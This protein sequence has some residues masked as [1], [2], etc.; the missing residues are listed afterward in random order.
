MTDN[1]PG[2]VDASDRRALL[3]L[4]QAV[5]EQ[6]STGLLVFDPGLRYLL[7]NQQMAAM[8]NTPAEALLGRTV[9]EAFPEYAGL[10]A[11]IEQVLATGEPMEAFD[12]SGQT[13]GW[14][15]T[16]ERGPCR[17]TG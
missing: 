14:W 4:L 15:A 6:S 16:S 11:R 5:C 8:A 13:P 12:V 17:R 7:V 3:T 9:R 10:T 1:P 2:V